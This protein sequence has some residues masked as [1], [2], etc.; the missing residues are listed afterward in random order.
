[1]T[2][3]NI[4]RM[5]KMVGHRIYDRTIKLFSPDYCLPNWA[6]HYLPS[7]NI[8]KEHKKV[9]IEYKWELK[10]YQV[11]ALMHIVENEWGLIEAMTWSWKS[12]I[13]MSIVDYYKIPTLIICP[14]K[15]LV[16]EMYDKFS[17]F[18]NYVPW[19]FYSDGKNIQDITITTHAS[20]VQDMQWDKKLQWFGI[21]IVDEADEKLSVNMIH[22]LCKCDCDI[23]VWMSGTPDRQELDIRDMQLIFWPHIRVW[24]YQVLPDSITH[25]VYKWEWEE[26]MQIDYTNRHTQRESI[27]ANKKRHESVIKTIEEITEKSFLSILLLDRM[28]EIEKY[29][30]AF[31]NAFIITWKTKVKDDEIW[32]EKLKNTWWLIIWSIKKMYRWIDIPPVDNVIIASPIRFENTVIQAVGRA[33]R[34]FEWKERVDISIINDNTLNSQRREQTK[35]CI[36]AYWITPT[37]VYI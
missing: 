12:H 14:T 8:P 32:I 7:K 3:K 31:P 21:V 25:Y 1:M 9:E 2:K 37:I 10:D 28:V 17:E 34:K 22:A 18:T 20:F 29:S 4:E 16:K 30:I 5:E 6:K 13:C 27:I 19:T 23:L 35:A 36:T 26:S 15:K 24:E 11:W 33:L